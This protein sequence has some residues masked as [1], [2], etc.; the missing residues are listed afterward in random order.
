MLAPFCFLQI[1]LSEKSALNMP[2]EAPVI[3]KVFF[4]QFTW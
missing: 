3:R 4:H 2:P 1:K